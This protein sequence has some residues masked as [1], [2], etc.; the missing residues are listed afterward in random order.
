MQSHIS[1]SD[2][3]FINGSN[4]AGNLAKLPNTP[5]PDSSVIFSAAGEKKQSI[6]LTSPGTRLEDSISP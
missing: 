3:A 1:S 2:A 4:M 5:K 6:C